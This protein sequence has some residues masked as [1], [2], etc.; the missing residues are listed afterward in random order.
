M[1]ILQ[2]SGPPC[3]GK[4]TLGR[5]IV[6]AHG[7]KL[8]DGDVM[9]PNGLAGRAQISSLQWKRFRQAR[10]RMASMWRPEFGPLVV[11][12][13]APIPFRA[14]V[15]LRVLNPGIVECH[16][17]ADADGRV[18][19]THVWIDKWFARWGD[20]PHTVGVD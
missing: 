8:L 9:S 19:E 12:R 20:T 16:R 1:N 10:D 17:R 7:G 4:S 3:S 13:G 11:L 14:G 2:I 15:K 6:E 5:Q 18:A